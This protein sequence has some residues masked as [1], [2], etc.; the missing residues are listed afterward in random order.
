MAMAEKGNGNQEVIGSKELAVANEFLHPLVPYG[1]TMAMR[2]MTRRIMLFDTGKV[3]MNAVEASHYAQVCISTRLNPFGYE[4]WALVSLIGNERRLTIMPGRRGLLRH[5]HEQAAARGTHFWPR[6]EQVTDPERRKNLMIPDGALA[7]ECKLYENL[8]VMTWNQSIVALT[9]ATKAGLHIDSSELG[10]TP[11]VFG[12]GILTADDMRQ[13]DKGSNKMS[14][15]ERCQKRA[16]MMAL[17]Q[18]F[19]LPLAGAVGPQG[20]TMEDYVPDA[21][22]REIP[23]GAAGEIEDQPEGRPVK[24][25]EQKAGDQ[26]ALYGEPTPATIAAVAVQIPA[27]PTPRMW[28][29]AFVVKVRSLFEDNGVM[30]PNEDR[31]H[32]IML[33]NLSP[34]E[35]SWSDADMI[36]WGKL[37]RGARDEGSPPKKAAVIATDILSTPVGF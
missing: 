12:L 8:S 34:F 23:V 27:S 13:L 4:V 35:E 1:P 31:K 30:P 32:L 10:P 37:Y 17:K 11:F 16:Y 24:T 28:S 26:A 2:E 20:E 22:W 5:A 25:D 33:L 19:D 18:M 3:K 6:Y 14:H 36:R 21:E 29:D 7:F 9:D 15:V